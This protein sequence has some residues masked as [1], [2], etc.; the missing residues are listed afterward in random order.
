MSSF[1]V[2]KKVKKKVRQKNEAYT[3]ER[4]RAPEMMFPEV[5]KKD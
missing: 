4:N 1:L 3:G 2:Y 5:K